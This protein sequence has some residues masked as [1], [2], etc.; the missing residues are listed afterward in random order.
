MVGDGIIYL[1][2]ALARAEDL[3][4]AGLSAPVCMFPPSLQSSPCTA[5]AAVALQLTTLSP[6]TYSSTRL[7]T[8]DFPTAVF[9][10]RATRQVPVLPKCSGKLPSCPQEIYTAI[11]RS[12][13][14][15]AAAYLHA[16]QI[17]Y[18]RDR[19]GYT[20][21]AGFCTP[22]SL[23]GH[24]VRS[25]HEQRGVGTSILMITCDAT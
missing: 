25:P 20:S 21:P 18:R 16:M 22:F 14:T 9:A 23:N 17:D 6:H 19:R 4:T 10:R 3:G 8:V 2:E 11:S 12:H 15:S 7:R 24:R 5:F 1:C 13:A